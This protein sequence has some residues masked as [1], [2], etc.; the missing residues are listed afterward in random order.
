MGSQRS[1]DDL[2]K[3]L[4]MGASALA[5]LDDDQLHAMSR[6]VTGMMN[7]DIDDRC[8]NNVL[9]WLQNHTATENPQHASLGLEYRVPF[10]IKTYFV[11]LFKAFET[12]KRLF[13]PKSRDMMTSWSVMGF[14]THRAQWFREETIV[15]TGSESKAAELVDYT[16]QLWD[17]QREHLKLRHPLKTKSTYEIAWEDGGRV[18]AIPSGEDKI[19]MFHPTRYVMDEAAFLPE[20]GNCYDAAHPVSIQII[21]I[22]TAAPGWFGLQCEK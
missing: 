22:S 7:D 21:A 9:W 5:E 20:A 16:R 15:Q 8:K 2:D 18:I 11:P 1:N 6:V 3:L 19:R 13:I 12:E 14:S 10:P 4:N 17:N